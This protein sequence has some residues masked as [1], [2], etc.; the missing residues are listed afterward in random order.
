MS[1]ASSSAKVR[2]ETPLSLTF[3]IFVCRDAKT[4]VSDTDPEIVTELAAKVAT[5][6][7]AFAF[8]DVNKDLNSASVNSTCSKDPAEIPKPE[9]LV[10]LSTAS[11][12]LGF[13]SRVPVPVK[14]PAS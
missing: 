13:T 8:A 12:A 10:E 14:P 4:V 9:R 11:L 5:L 2:P 1:T 3:A 7:A 6:P